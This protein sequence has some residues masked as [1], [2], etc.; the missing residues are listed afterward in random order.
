M[1]RGLGRRFRLAGSWDGSNCLSKDDFKKILSEC[2]VE[3]HGK[4]CDVTQTF[5]P[6]FLIKIRH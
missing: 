6:K 4:E 2:G 1:L 3:L 5:P